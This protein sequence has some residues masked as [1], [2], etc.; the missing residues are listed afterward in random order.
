VSVQLHHGDRREGLGDRPDPEHRV[1]ID[2]RVRRD[3]REPVPVEELKGPVSHDP[4]RQTDGGMPVEDPIYP[5]PQPRLVE[6]HV[7]A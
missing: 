4:H 5:R 3:V 2:R 1:R 6:P 7:S